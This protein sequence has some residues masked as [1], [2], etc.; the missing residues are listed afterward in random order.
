MLI[1]II[2]AALIVV[3]LALHLRGATVVNL[4][5]SSVVLYPIGVFVA[6]QVLGPDGGLMSAPPSKPASGVPY[7]DTYV[8][9]ANFA[10]LGWIMGLFALIAL[11]FWALSRWGATLP[12]DRLKTLFWLLHIAIIALPFVLYVFISSGVYASFVGDTE[13]LPVFAMSSAV[14][15]IFCLISVAGF[16]F[17]ALTAVI[18]R[19][20]A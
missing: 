20:R 9:V 3:P 8:F 4:A 5:L 2:F 18:T 1:W 11:V 19:L 13:T 17:T 15:S 6:W 10:V 16:L 12:H 7:S 14:V